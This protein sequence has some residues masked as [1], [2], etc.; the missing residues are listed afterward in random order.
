MIKDSV[1]VLDIGTSKVTAMIG[2]NGVNGNFI[3]RSISEIPCI[4]LFGDEFADETSL[5]S[6]IS[7]AL[8]NVCKTAS[9]ILKE[10]TV[11][12]PSAFLIT[13]NREYE[14]SYPHRKRLRERDVAQYMA[15]AEEY[16]DLKFAGFQPIMSR[17]MFFNLDG[18]RRVEKPILP[19]ITGLFLK[20]YFPLRSPATAEIRAK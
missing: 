20:G 8:L 3:I 9:V 4:S 5:R 17:G 11:S 10:I 18:N 14:K 1:A 7:Q 13:R 2:E 15:E 6:A 12:V 16:A 19:S